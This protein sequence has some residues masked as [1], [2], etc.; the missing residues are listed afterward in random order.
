MRLIIRMVVAKRTSGL[1]EFIIG[2][3]GFWVLIQYDG[4]GN[5][6]Y[7]K[8]T[9]KCVVALLETKISNA[10]NLGSNE[11]VQDSFLDL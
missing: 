10:V 8:D 5:D 1:Q 7:L 4:A 9:R 3:V 11:K 6:Y 2:P